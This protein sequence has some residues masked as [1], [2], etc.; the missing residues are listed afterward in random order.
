MHPWIKVNFTSFFSAFC[1]LKR[2]EGVYRYTLAFKQDFLLKQRSTLNAGCLSRWIPMMLVR[3]LKLHT[4][5]SKAQN[6]YRYTWTEIGQKI[7]FTWQ[8]PRIKR[9]T[10]HR[11]IVHVMHSN[12]SIVET[13]G[14]QEVQFLNHDMLLAW[15][16]KQS[17]A[18]SLFWPKKSQQNTTSYWCRNAIDEYY[19]DTI[20]TCGSQPGRLTSLEKVKSHFRGDE[21]RLIEEVE[22]LPGRFLLQSLLTKR[23]KL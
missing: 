14:N 7:F 2:A 1:K 18:G 21:R 13:N 10:N 6:N 19:R 15:P 8:Q 12:A 5:Y 9:L 17:T 4:L 20:Y 23:E 3:S 22:F 16:W 11:R